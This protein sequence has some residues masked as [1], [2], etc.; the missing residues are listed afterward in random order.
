MYTETILLFDCTFSYI[1]VFEDLI[2]TIKLVYA[3]QYAPWQTNAFCV[4]CL[5][6]QDRNTTHL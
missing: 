5:T 1:V 6:E 3:I 2:I 4:H